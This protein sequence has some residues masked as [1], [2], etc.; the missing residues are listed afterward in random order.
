[1]TGQQLKNSILQMAVQGKLVPQNPNDEPASV[2]LERIRKEKEQLIKEG[3]IKREKNLSYIFRGADNLPYEKVGKNEPVCIADEVPFEIPD[4]W[5]WVRFSAVIELQSG[6]DMTPDKYN[7]AK[8]G[9]PY[10]TGASNIE[11]EK[12]I[13]NR[14]T[15]YGKAFA[16]KGDL[17]I[18]CKGTIGTMAILEENQVHIARQIMAIRSGNL[19]KIEYIQLVLETLVASL[20]AAAKSMIPGVSREDILSSLLPL[21]PYNEQSKI[22]AFFK[23]VTPFIDEYSKKESQLQNL[24][25]VFPELLKK[26]ILQEAVQGKLVPQDP[27]DEPASVLLKRIRS[28]KEQ[29]IKAGKIK[30][31]KHESVIF[32]RDNSHYEKLDGIDRCIDDEIPFEIPDSWVWERWG[33]ISQS[34]QYGY[35]APAKDCGRIKMVR[36]SDIQD[37]SVLWETVPYCD[38]K[39]NEISTYLLQPNDI[40]F[41]RTGGTVGKSY[42]VQEVPEEAIYA[43]YLIRTRYSQW[44][45]PQYLKFFME[46]EL[47]W[48]QLRNGTIATAQPNCNGRTLGKMLLPI[49][50]LSEQYRIV[51]K[52]NVLFGH[53]NSI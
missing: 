16:Y 1:M 50:P 24:N 42:L 37:N 30:R 52:V 23:S 7:S 41:A 5:E 49:P 32:R 51:E 53:C 39:E 13:I 12:V 26:S 27:A 40:L 4:T 11:N 33:N 14:W 47:Y 10:L 44:L 22:I 38:I 43:G 19:I 46:S 29:L 8:Q 18:T 48:S 20:K 25:C 31:D 3:K 45:Y 15:E 6:Q 17:L 9:I 21:P 28:E 2:L 34:I 35:N 36:I